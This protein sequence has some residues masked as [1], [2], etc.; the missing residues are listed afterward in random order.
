VIGSVVGG[1]ILETLVVGELLAG[2]PADLEAL[3]TELLTVLGRSGRNVQRDGQPV[4]DTADRGR[5]MAE[6]VGT[7][8]EKRLPVL[9]RLGVLEAQL[10]P[11]PRG[12]AS[13]SVEL[14]H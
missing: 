4:T 5:I 10:N 13:G 6:A 3:T 11:H 12:A 14:R 1:D 9:R 7:I 2:K 8:L